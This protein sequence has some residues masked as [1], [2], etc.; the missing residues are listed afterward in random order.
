MRVTYWHVSWWGLVKCGKFV[1]DGDWGSSGKRR[2]REHVVGY[3]VCIRGLVRLDIER[4]KEF[5]KSLAVESP[6]RLRDLGVLGETMV[7]WSCWIKE[8]IFKIRLWDLSKQALLVFIGGVL[9]FA[10]RYEVYRCG[11][12]W[13]VN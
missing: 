10:G 11:C 9:V 13:I 7:L 12:N 6:D 8:H 5:G 1:D 2:T 3:G 4:L